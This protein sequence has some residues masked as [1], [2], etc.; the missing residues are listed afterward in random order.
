MEG[1]FL[2]ETTKDLSGALFDSLE[3]AQKVI[4]VVLA[5]DG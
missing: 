4:E 5:L 2:A 3:D 1:R